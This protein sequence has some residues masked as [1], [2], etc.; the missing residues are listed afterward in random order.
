LIEQG[1]VGRKQID[2]IKAG[3]L[4]ALCGTGKTF[5]NL[6]NFAFAHHVAAIRIVIGGQARRRPMRHEGK[7]RIAMLPDMVELLQDGGAMRVH[8]VGKFAK[9]RNDFIVAVAKIAPGQYCSRVYRHRF[10]HD[11]RRAADGAFFVIAAVTFTR[12]PKFGH[13]GGMRTENYTVIESAMAQFER[14]KQILI[15]SHLVINVGMSR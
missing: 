4:A 15:L 13:V 6:E 9:V 1:V 2:T 3:C 5:D 7:V 10:D 8:R 12:Q 11:H 14:L